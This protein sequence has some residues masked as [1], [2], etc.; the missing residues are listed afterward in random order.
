MALYAIGDLHL[1]LGAPKPMDIFRF[2][3]VNYGKLYIFTSLYTHF[4]RRHTRAG[5]DSVKSFPQ[6]KPTGIC[7]AEKGK[8][9]PA[10][11]S[12]DIA[13]RIA[14]SRGWT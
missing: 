14:S 9:P 3:G 6:G 2:F 12:E 7:I 4:L 13:R 10:V 8:L 11:V 1:C 5:W